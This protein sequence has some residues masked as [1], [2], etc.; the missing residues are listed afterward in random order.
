ML[1]VESRKYEII[2]LSSVVKVE[3][4]DG[5]QTPRQQRYCQPRLADAA[6]VLSS[7]SKFAHEVPE[8]KESAAV[9][10]NLRADSDRLLGGLLCHSRGVQ[11]GSEN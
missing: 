1:Q 11:K 9:S 6:A 3:A 5:G 8:S 7:T 10:A 4:R 2:L